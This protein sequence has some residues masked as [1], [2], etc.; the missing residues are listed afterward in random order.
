MSFA[1]SDPFCTDT[2]KIALTL[3]VVLVVVF[4]LPNVTPSAPC[5]RVLQVSRS[6]PSCLRSTSLFPNEYRPHM[7]KLK[8]NT[9][10]GNGH[11][12]NEVD[13]ACSESLDG[14]ES[15][16][17]SLRRS[18]SFP[19]LVTGPLALQMWRF[20]GL[21][22]LFPDFKK[23]QGSAASAEMTRQVE[24]STLSAHQLAPAGI[25]AHSSSWTPAAFELEE[26]GTPT[27]VVFQNFLMEEGSKETKLRTF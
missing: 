7:K 6:R 4:C 14:T 3:S 21:F 27:S 17:S 25:V 19:P 26:S 20:K 24:I 23:V 8:Y 18:L 11:F 2:A 16:T 5:R 1:E 12:D 22:A 9:H 15:T 10:V 13:L